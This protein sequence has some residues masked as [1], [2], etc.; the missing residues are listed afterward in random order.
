MAQCKGMG[1]HALTGRLSEE[2]IGGM[3][4]QV[5]AQVEHWLGEGRKNEK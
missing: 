3:V 2:E 5:M 1:F 4:G